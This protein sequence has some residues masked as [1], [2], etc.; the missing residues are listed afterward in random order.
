ML[1]I[2]AQTTLASLAAREDFPILSQMVHG[3]PLVY[4]DS[5]ATAQKP[6]A[7]LDAMDR[8]YRTT[9]ANVHRG[10]YALSE[11]AS[12]H[13]ED[14]RKK[15]ARFIHA[16][17]VREVIFTRNATE[18]LNLVA[19]TWGLANIGAGDLI[20][21]TEMEHH[22]NLVP[23]QMLAARTG[24]ILDFIPVTDDG[25]LDQAAY[26]QLL[27]RSPKL[28]AFSLMSNVLGTITPAQTM[29]AQAHAAGA[30]VVCDGAQS[31]A[32]LPTDV[33]ELDCDFLAFSAHKMLGPTGIGVLYGKRALLEA[34]PPFMGG[35]DMIRE[36]HLRS[37]TTNE[38]PWKF[39]AGTP[40]IA[41]AIG[42]GAAVDYLSAL[43]MAAVADHEAALAAQMIAL[44]STLPAVRIIGPLSG[45]R[46]AV[47]SFTVA[48]MH[49]HDL[50]TLLDADGIAVR[51]G[52][53]CAQPLMERFGLPATA[54]ASAYV[55]TNGAEIAALVAGVDRA[56]MLFHQG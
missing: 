41:E 25:L 49:P 13:Y 54:R 47:V 43:G 18:G 30:V 1:D 33:R 8:Y 21:L 34:M 12:T 52:H 10:A 3:K 11:A 28:V 15:V 19:Q 44:L 56:S 4:L 7:V 24:A 26:A 17:S 55:Y 14:A 5:T 45:P 16:R 39:E 32:H 53:H 9:N 40:A 37:F 31:V 35:G 2:S 38:L 20:V 23:W 36:V 22:S 50:A 42:L 29:I 46:G 27:E 51:A 48:D 6:L